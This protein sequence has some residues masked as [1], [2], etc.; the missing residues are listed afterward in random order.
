MDNVNDASSANS[1]SQSSDMSF[2]VFMLAI[3]VGMAFYV[4]YDMEQRY[5]T[6][7]DT[8]SS[9]AVEPEAAPVTKAA[10][11]PVAVSV[12]KVVAVEASPDAVAVEKTEQKTAVSTT[13]VPFDSGIIVIPAVKAKTEE[14]KVKAAAPVVSEKVA[15]KTVPVPAPAPAPAPAP[16]P[17]I[18]SMM[19]TVEVIAAPVVDAA[20]VVTEAI[21]APQPAAP[22]YNPYYPKKRSSPCN[23][24]ISST[25]LLIIELF[26]S[27][28]E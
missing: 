3:I 14:A 20:E 25:K 27:R 4:S 13:V 9:I 16:L 5:G 17:L 26:F 23:D 19:Q 7:A 1:A 2:Y 18:D 8:T 6:S 12:E 21:P 28:L 24:I 22:A 10:A 15:E 11:K